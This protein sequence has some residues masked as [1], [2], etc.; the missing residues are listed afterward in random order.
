MGYALSEEQA[1]EL[2]A[3][4][5]KRL[6]MKLTDEQAADAVIEE[7]A[8]RLA[9]DQDAHRQRVIASHPDAI[10]LEAQ[11]EKERLAFVRDVEQRRTETANRILAGDKAGQKGRTPKGRGK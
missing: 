4:E 8:E 3:L 10:A 5:R 11:I 7:S 9:A 2:T 1:G 6:G